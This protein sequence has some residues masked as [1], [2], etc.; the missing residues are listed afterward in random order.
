MDTINFYLYISENI[1]IVKD[2]FINILEKPLNYTNN[3]TNN[4][5]IKG[6]LNNL[7][8]TLNGNRLKVSGSVCKYYYGDNLKTL[9]LLELNKAIERLSNDLQ[10]DLSEAIVTRIDFADQVS[11]RHYI[12][13]YMKV[14]VYKPRM[15]ITTFDD[16]ISLSN[17]SSQIC[18]YDKNTE[19][20][21]RNQII[22]LHFDKT[23]IFRFE[24]RETK[25]KKKFKANKLSFFLNTKGYLVLLDNWYKNY[26]DILKIEYLKKNIDLTSNIIKI[27]NDCIY[28]RL[29]EVGFDNIF[30]ELEQLS[31]LGI[32][33]PNQ[34]YERK[35]FIKKIVKPDKK[36]TGV[37]IAEL[38]QKIELAYNLHKSRTLMAKS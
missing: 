35:K 34:K 9:G 28:E 24:V 1:D 37:L 12:T 21:K 23:K 18:S 33:S 29:N 5:F 2:H 8:I 30:N 13:E 15:V 7:K 20:K 4:P 32:L 11:T 6:T 26:K 38:D 10:V 3:V 36:E 25:L 27:K 16:G 17:D 31:S 22:P 14:M 19:M